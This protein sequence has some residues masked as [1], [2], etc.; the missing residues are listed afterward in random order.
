MP[1]EHATHDSRWKRTFFT[2]RAGQAFSLPGSAAAQFALIWWLTLRTGSPV[3]PASLGRVFALVTSLMSL[4]IPVGLFVAGP[5]AG[6]VG[7]ASWFSISGGLIVAAA[8]LGFLLTRREA[9]RETT[10]AVYH[11]WTMTGGIAPCYPGRERSTIMETYH[12]VTSETD[13]RGLYTFAG[14]AA[15]V[16]LAANLLDVFLGFGETEVVAGGTRT[17]VEWFALFREDGFGGLYALGLLNLVYQSCLVPVF[18][19]L[20]VAHRRAD[21]ALAALALIV[22][23]LGMAIYAA[24]NA[25]IPMHVLAGRYAAAGS[26]A[27]RALLAAAGEAAL[28][29][30]EDFTPGAFVGTLFQSL[31]A[32]GFALVLLRGRAFGRPTG[33]I[34][35]AG[36]TLLTVFTVWATFVPVLYGVAFYGF[37]MTGGL[38]VLAWFLLVGLRFFRLARGGTAEPG[39]RQ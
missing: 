31:A 5:L 34:G 16:A 17:A 10:Q 1:S 13:R 39:G 8:A 22:S 30:G 7:I 27:R 32:L 9:S 38:L 4:A 35:T 23:L 12:P 36:F 26:E 6:L 20:Y 37:G 21:G 2:I 3:P 28:A 14:V 33:W 29:R 15:L 18:L 19:A 11:I 24:N 25:A